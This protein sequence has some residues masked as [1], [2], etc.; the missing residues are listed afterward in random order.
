[1]PVAATTI[2]S[3]S[4]RG[5]W[6][7]CDT[8]PHTTDADKIHPIKAIW[9]GLRQSSPIMPIDRTPAIVPIKPSAGGR[10]AR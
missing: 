4:L 6:E 9:R 8:I 10:T 5:S 7:R 1:M 3:D 2:Y